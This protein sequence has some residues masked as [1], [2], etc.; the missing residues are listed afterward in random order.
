MNKIN[1]IP[2]ARQKARAKRRHLALWILSGVAYCGILST[3]YVACYV[4]WASPIRPMEDEIAKAEA[5][6]SEMEHALNATKSQVD[7][8]LQQLDS[9]HSVSHQPDW[10]TLLALVSDT[11]GPDIVLTK[12]DLKR[13]GGDLPTENASSSSA[14]GA[15]NTTP[16]KPTNPKFKPP[17]PEPPT[18]SLIA[19]G[20][21]RSPAS[22]SQFSLR[23]ESTG[24]FERVTLIKTMR[25]PFKDRE[26]TSFN[27][28][29][30]LK[31]KG[32]L[33]R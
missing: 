8:L 11:L 31:G 9:A 27:I 14:K 28:E 19:S 12:C 16:P 5:S 6:E 18:W 10:S 7:D 29:C 26:A 17:P 21:G 3:V 22:V 25:E 23:L 20:L 15:S 4:A 33:I 13:T 1:L 2:S 32:K 24:L 30:Q